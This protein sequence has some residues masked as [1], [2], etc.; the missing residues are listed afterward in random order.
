MELLN[1]VLDYSGNDNAIITSTIRT[2]ESQASAMYNNLQKTS[3][4]VQKDIYGNTG[5]QV[6]DVYEM[7]K[8][9]GKSKNEII[10]DMVDKINELWP[11]R[12]S[13][14]VVPLEEYKKL[15]VIDISQSSIENDKEFIRQ[16]QAAKESGVI[17]NYL[18][19]NKVYHLEVYVR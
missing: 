18:I 19:E 17:K 14:H 8:K 3:V 15:N 9:L 2:P 4:D 11:S 12:V 1:Q 16:L 5:E 7:G 6:I 10:N 13:L